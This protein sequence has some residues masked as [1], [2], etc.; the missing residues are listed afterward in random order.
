MIKLANN[1][2]ESKNKKNEVKTC[3]Q[4]GPLLTINTNRQVHTLYNTLRLQHNCK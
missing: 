1:N 3:D 2:N 4:I